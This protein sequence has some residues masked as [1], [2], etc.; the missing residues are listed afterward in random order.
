M[1][2][3][4]KEERHRLVTGD[5]LVALTLSLELAPI[6]CIDSMVIKKSFFIN[7][8]FYENTK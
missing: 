6:S 7:L 5:P 8:G 1:Y 3:N 2:N 4:G